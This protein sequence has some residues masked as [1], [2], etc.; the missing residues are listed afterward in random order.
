[1][2]YITGFSKE[3]PPVDPA[4]MDEVRALLDKSDPKLL[5]WVGGIVSGLILWLM[6]FK[7]F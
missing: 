1:M 6:T 3:N 5:T 7:P 4:S 2:P